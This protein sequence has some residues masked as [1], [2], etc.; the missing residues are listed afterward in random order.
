MNTKEDQELLKREGTMR[1]KE[2]KVNVI[3]YPSAHE[4]SSTLPYG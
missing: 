3:A 1:W 2:I 4:F